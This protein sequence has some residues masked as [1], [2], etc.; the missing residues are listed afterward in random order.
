MKRGDITIDEAE[1]ALADFSARLQS[2]LDE[3]RAAAPPQIERPARRRLVE[4]PPL[5]ARSRPASTRRRS[6]RSPASSHEPPDGF[7]VHPK[8][9]RQLEQRARALRSGRGR[10]GARRG[11]RARL[12]A[13][14]RAS[15]SASPA[16]TPGAAPSRQRHAVLVDYETG[17]EYMPLV[18][19]RAS[20][21]RRVPP[22]TPAGVG[23]FRVYDSL[24]SE[25]AALGFEY[26]YSVESPRRPR[27]LGG[28]VRRLRQ[29]RPDH[30]RQL[31]RRRR[32]EVG[33]ELRRSCCCCRTATRDRAPSTPRRASS[34]SCSCR[35]GEQHHR[36]PADDGGAVLPPAASAGHSDRSAARS[37]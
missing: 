19:P 4:V 29:R 16:R 26:G 15:T 10:L 3:T 7:T 9:A 8:L 20:A 2:A 35:A 13:R 5:L 25:Y 22:R 12:A 21:P 37:S 31:P 36:R 17:E 34:A 1:Q 24:L 33:P 14:S 32:G 11:A 27:R 23:R 30:H 6:T 28:A 18:G